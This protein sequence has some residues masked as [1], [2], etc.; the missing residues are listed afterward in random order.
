LEKELIENF[1]KIYGNYPEIIS[2]A[3]GRINIIG[4][5]TDYTLGYV[6]PA[7]IN[8]NIYFL[9][10]KRKDL[11]VK[12]FSIQF[13]EGDSFKIG[14]IES[15]SIKTWKNYVRGIFNLFFERDFSISGVNG[16]IYGNIPIGAGLSSSAALE[17]SIINGLNVLFDME[18]EKIEIACV[19][20]KVEQ[21]F[22]GVRCGIMDQFISVFGKKSTAIFLDCETLSF[23][24]IPLRLDKYNLSILICNTGI[25]RDLAETEYNKRREE[26][27]NALNIFKNKYGI[28][29][30]K[31][32]N[33]QILENEKFILGDK[34]YKRA[35]HI[36]NENIRVKRAVNA[37]KNDDFHTLRELIFQSHKSLRDD[38]EVSC[39]ELDFLYEIGLKFQGCYGA[40][41]MGA[42]FGGSVIILIEENKI[43]DFKKEVFKD[44]EK[45]GFKKPHFYKVCISKGANVKI[46]N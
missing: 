24:E 25:K 29:S 12:I 35:R 1:I 14:E 41:L 18:L 28:K 36:I 37:L 44:F 2:C 39:Q 15:F 9:A 22:A 26:A 34:L 17:V 32:V 38:Y 11:R 13:K 27:E 7:S 45:K 21:D 20:Q 8:K 5:H 4:E 40:R 30:F 23:E 6:L 10:S 43:E 42:G 19:A 16:L 46:L 31:D 3:P 33:S